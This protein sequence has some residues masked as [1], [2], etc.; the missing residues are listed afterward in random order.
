M[1]PMPNLWDS[2]YVRKMKPFRIQIEE[3]KD[4]STSGKLS[5]LQ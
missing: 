3:I 4:M 1:I 5:L 2:L